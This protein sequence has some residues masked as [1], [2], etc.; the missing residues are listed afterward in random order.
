M[1]VDREWGDIVV[2]ICDNDDFPCLQRQHTGNL[3]LITEHSLRL[4]Q[5]SVHNGRLHKLALARITRNIL[6]TMTDSAAIE[7]DNK[8]LLFGQFY[9]LGLVGE[10]FALGEGQGD[11]C[12]AQGQGEEKG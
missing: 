6:Y 1:P 12:W 8:F 4:R 3:I 11:F 5:W 2:C 7:R 10:G 9:E